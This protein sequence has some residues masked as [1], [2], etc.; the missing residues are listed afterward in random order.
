M[1]DL[2]AGSVAAFKAFGLAATINPVTNPAMD[3]QLPGLGALDGV[4]SR[5]T[6]RQVGS[7]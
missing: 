3:E 6:T 2:R 1:A 5:Y 7:L 4:D